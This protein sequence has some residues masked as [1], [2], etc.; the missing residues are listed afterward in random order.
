[1]PSPVSPSSRT[2]LVL[3]GALAA[4]LAVTGCSRGAG[5]IP[6]LSKRSIYAGIFTKIDQAEAID[7]PLARCLAYPDPPH[8]AW[9][10]PL[11]EALCGDVRTPS[12]PIDDLKRLIDRRDWS[13]LHERYAVICSAT[14]AAP[15]RRRSSTGRFRS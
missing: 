14:A 8:L 4:C 5:E 15:T 3:I 6:E 10:R 1:M 2:A 12:M 13:G 9:P 7:D 11:V